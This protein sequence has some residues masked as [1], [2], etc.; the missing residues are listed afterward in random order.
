MEVEEM[1]EE[2]T[3]GAGAGE[4]AGLNIE[5]GDTA[6]RQRA[7]REVK[8]VVGSRMF[9]EASSRLKELSRM[10]KARWRKRRW[11]V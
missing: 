2:A 1:M 7:M 11:F 10:E 6:A 5:A 4:T 9:L 3:V 8:N